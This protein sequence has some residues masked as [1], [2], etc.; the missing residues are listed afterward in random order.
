MLTNIII[1]NKISHIEHECN[2][3][4]TIKMFGFWIYLMSDCILFATLFATYAVLSNGVVDQL[5]RRNIFELF[6]VLIETF[7][8]LFSSFS[9]GMAIIAMLRD[10]SSFVN[11]WLFV[12]FLLG[13]SFVC[14]EFYE[15]RHL[16]SIGYGPDRDAFLSSFFTL[17]GTHGLHVVFGLIWIL[18][19][20][21]QV[22]LN[23][24]NFINKIRLQCL[25][26]FWHFLDIVWICVFTM[27]Y[28]I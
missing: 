21:V 6:L 17:V 27:V 15:F 10:K 16:I 24:L 5:I 18:V 19:I 9:Y 20:S 2:N 7:L 25:G 3:I 13:I 26:L 4:S 23:G 14:I 22:F 8:L 12:T 28:L 11:I 1:N